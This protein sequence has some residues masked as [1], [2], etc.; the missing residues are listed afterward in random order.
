MRAPA[1]E[2]ELEERLAAPAAADVAG[3]REL[4]GDVIVLG[5]S[6]KMGPSLVRRIKRAADA[7]GGSRRITAVA[8]FLDADARASLDAEGVTTIPADLADPTQV[9]RLPDAPHVLFLVGRKFGTGDQAH[10][11]WATN[12]VS[13]ALALRRYAASRVVVLSTGNVYPLVRPEDGGSRE[14]DPL[15]PVG[16]YAQSC[17]GRE[18]IAEYCSR[19]NGTRVLLVRL[20]YASDLRYGV[21]VDVARRVRVG[22]PVDLSV[23]HVNTIWQGDANSYVLRGLAHCTSPPAAL[24]VTGPDV[25]RV[26]D[27]AERF[28]AAFGRRPQFVGRADGRALLSNPERAIQLLGPPTVSSD[29]LIDWTA[30]WVGRGGQ[31]LNKPTSYELTSGQF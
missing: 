24:N 27:V 23:G 7:A 21:L 15:A 8:R 4:A 31:L 3:L 5:A 9:D 2:A 17:L 1:S 25:L 19:I 30:E 20:N 18:R 12:T 11:T 26:Q 28:G 22:E 29:E 6:G 13:P 16:E 10:L 14:A